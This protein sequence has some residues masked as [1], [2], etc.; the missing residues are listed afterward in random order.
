MAR[1][2]SRDRKYVQS[3]TL[4]GQPQSKVWFTHADLVQGGKLELTMG[5]QPQLTLG[6]DAKDLP[7]SALNFNP[8]V[9]LK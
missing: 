1:N 8:A 9:L 3:V 7:P 5:E 2:N 4:N 6:T